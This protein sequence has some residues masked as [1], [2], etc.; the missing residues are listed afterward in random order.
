MTGVIP[1]KRVQERERDG[2]ARQR[3]QE[4][5]LAA[6]C[7]TLREEHE[8]KYQRLQEDWT[9]VQETQ[10]KARWGAQCGSKADPVEFVVAGNTEGG[11]AAGSGTEGD[12]A[13]PQ[14]ARREGEQLQP[15][16][17]SVGAAGPAVGPGS[18]GRVPEPARLIG[19]GWR[20]TQLCAAACQVVYLLTVY[21][22]LLPLTFDL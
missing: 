11:A 16:E 19:S 22:F 4:S 20:D 7:Q 6:V 15:N 1:L 17:R 14:D 10:K 5:L 8:A 3:E 12:R 9:Q 18:A 2:C 13:P 21:G